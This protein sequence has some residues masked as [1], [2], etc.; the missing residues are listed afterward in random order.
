[1]A[2]LHLHRKREH[3]KNLSKDPNGH[4]KTPPRQ[5]ALWQGFMGF[6]TNKTMTMYNMA[7][8]NVCLSPDTS[9]EMLIV[10]F[11]EHKRSSLG[12]EH[13]VTGTL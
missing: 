11:W 6:N 1:M 5:L 10:N 2:F 9:K 12:S 7:T 3:F 13:M 4:M 8:D